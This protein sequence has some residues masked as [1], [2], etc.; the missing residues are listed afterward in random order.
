[1]C[2]RATLTTP[3]EQIAEAFGVDAVP[4]GPPRYNVA[5]GQPIVVVRHGREVDE[6]ALLKWGLLPWWSKSEKTKKPLVQ[7]R[8]ETVATAPA[9][10]D[11]F[12]ARRCLVVVDGF[13][14]WKTLGK[15]RVP[16]HVHRQD[17]ALFALAGVWDRWKSADGEIVETCAVVTTDAHGAVRDLHDRMPLVLEGEA[18]DVWLHG[19]AEDASALVAGASR[20]Q[21]AVA[22][23][24]DV[25]PVS[26]WVNDVR[27]DDPRCLEPPVAEPDAPA[28]HDGQL[29]LKLF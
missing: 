5:P 23:A 7:A 18:R 25:A 20:S 26:K 29:G 11:A 15:E 2:G 1:M 3:V 14:E 21:E 28:A 10:R 17:G 4:I 22:S 6:L 19:S 27:H 13:Y 12:K 9:F 24:L 8:A 16:H